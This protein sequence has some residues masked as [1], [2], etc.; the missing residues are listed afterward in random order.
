[1]DEATIIPR[2]TQRARLSRCAA[3]ILAAAPC[4]VAAE[5]VQFSVRVVDDGGQQLPARV[6]VLDEAG[7]SFLPPVATTVDIGPDSWF[8][9]DGAARLDVPAGRYRVQVERGPEY[10]RA[11]ATV[12]LGANVTREFSLHRWIDM[13]ARG[14]RSGENHLHVPAAEVAPMMAAED[15]D[16]GSSLSW[17]NGQK[18]SVQDPNALRNATLLD[19]EVENEWGA[20][21]CVG[22]AHPMPVTWNPARANLTYVQAARVAGALISYQGGWSREVLVDALI[23]HVDAVNVGDNLFHRYKFMPRAR[24]SNLLGVAGLPDYPGTPDG[25]LALATESYYRLL[26]CGLRLAAG[27]GSATGVKS[28]PPGYNRAYV[29]LGADATVREFLAAWRA[30]RNFV[31]NGPMLFLRANDAEPGDTIALPAAGGKVRVRA[32]A[33]SSDPLRTLAI[34]VNGRTMATGSNGTVEAELDLKEGAWIAAVA[35]AEEPGADTD[36]ERY[37]QPSRLGGEAPTRLHFAHTSPIYVTVGG[38]GARVA[39]SVAEAGRMLDAFEAFARK[40]AAPEFQDE[41]IQAVATARRKL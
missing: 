38:V 22:L 13:R 24:Y 34:M 12:T 14:Y 21:Y 27:A 18:F 15:L 2:S 6:L 41:I 4:L 32:E 11:S 25:M 5:I 9:C 7:R 16:F 30:G 19:A 1:M 10:E 36:L 40:T 8:A 28:S 39:S 35:T 17:W 20:V 29:R 33:L 23:G 37:R 26:N 31:T 3:A